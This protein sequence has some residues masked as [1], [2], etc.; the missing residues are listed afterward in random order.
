MIRIYRVQDS[1]VQL[2]YWL[3]GLGF[4]IYR[5]LAFGRFSGLRLQG[6]GLRGLT[7][8]LGLVSVSD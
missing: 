1:G 2:G 3:W 5:I 6:F 4:W 7:R 8:V